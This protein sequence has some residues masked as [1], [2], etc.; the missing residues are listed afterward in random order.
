MTFSLLCVAN[1]TQM[2]SLEGTTCALVHAAR[3]HRNR[4]VLDHTTR[5]FYF[6]IHVTRSSYEWTANKIYKKT[7]Y[8][9]KC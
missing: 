2:H 8:V 1:F 3:R 9:H 6:H 7:I 4:V 5:Q